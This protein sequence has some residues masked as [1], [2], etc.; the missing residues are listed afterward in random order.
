MLTKLSLTFEFWFLLNSTGVRFQNAQRR[1]GTWSGLRRETIANHVRL[2]RSTVSSLTLKV[3]NILQDHVSH[4]G[5]WRLFMNISHLLYS[6][7]AP[8]STLLYV[9][10]F[11]SFYVSLLFILFLRFKVNISFFNYHSPDICN[12][13]GLMSGYVCVL[14]CI[15]SKT[16]NVLV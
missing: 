4:F 11:P 3:P 13:C 14:V 16:H 9:L 5:K 6:K 7:S 1:Q 15:S 12:F 8:P 2:I 10:V